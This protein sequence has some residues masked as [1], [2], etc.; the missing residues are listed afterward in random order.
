MYGF[1][2]AVSEKPS[3]TFAAG[4]KGS[5]CNNSLLLT[6]QHHAV[7]R[8]VL[9]WVERYTVCCCLV[10]YSVSLGNVDADML[11]NIQKSYSIFR[12]LLKLPEL[13]VFELLI[14]ALLKINFVAFVTLMLPLANFTLLM[15]FLRLSYYFACNVCCS[16]L[17]FVNLW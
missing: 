7:F 14:L 4:C 15:K 8:P 10:V 1:G 2:T 9:H 13:R 5:A 6:R 11:Q 17:F 16:I 12:Q 3:F